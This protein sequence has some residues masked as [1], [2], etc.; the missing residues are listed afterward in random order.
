MAYCPG[1]KKKTVKKII[2][3]VNGRSLKAEIR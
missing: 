1:G 3:P 2:E